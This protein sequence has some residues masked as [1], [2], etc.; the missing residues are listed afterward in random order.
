M[1]IITKSD[2]NRWFLVQKSRNVIQRLF[3]RNESRII[4]FGN[5]GPQHITQVVTGQPELYDYFTETEL[6]SKVNE[7]AGDSNYYKEQAETE[8]NK[9]QGPSGLYPPIEID[10]NEELNG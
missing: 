2:E 3:L 7:V 8:G 1:G 10:L 4:L 6:E 5:A 9:F